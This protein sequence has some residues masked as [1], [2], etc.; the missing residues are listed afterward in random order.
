MLDISRPR[1]DAWNSNNLPIYEPGLQEVVL[2]CRGKNLSFSTEVEKHVRDADIIFVSV[3]TPTKTQ[4]T[5]CIWYIPPDKKERCCLHLTVMAGFRHRGRGSSGSEV[6]GV[7]CTHY[8]CC[9]P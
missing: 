3:N 4:G 8:R 2:A 9:L 7:C 1:I 6:L 5:A